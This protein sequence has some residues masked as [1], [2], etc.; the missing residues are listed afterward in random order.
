MSTEARAFSRIFA[1]LMGLAALIWIWTVALLLAWPWDKNPQWQ[2]D[3]RIVALCTSGNPC[4]IPVATLAQSGERIKTLDLPAELG[5]AGDEDEDDAWLKWR[6]EA[7]DSGNPWQW[8]VTRS[9]W[10]FETIVRYRLDDGKPVLLGRRHVD[11]N[12]FLYAIPLGLFTL[13]GLI[14]RSFRRG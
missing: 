3:D 7:K 6:R 5:A 12:L 1:W 2:A 14:L 9:S 4:S 8:E 11:A 13:F 10:H